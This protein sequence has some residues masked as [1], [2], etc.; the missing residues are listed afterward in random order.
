MT[1]LVD[2]STRVL[3][4]GI[5]G[6]EGSFHTRQ[7]VEYG[8]N[9]VAGVTPGKGGQEFEGIPV[10]DTVSAAVEQTGADVSV[11]FVPPP[12]AGD[13]IM[14]SAEAGI[15]LVVC[16]TEGIPVTD[17]VRAY[18]YIQQRSTRLIG[19]NCPGIMRSWIW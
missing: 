17:M 2:D 1:I 18:Q 6:G 8:T 7:M 5:T 14:E 9:V 16:I 10:Y 4:Q 11:I 12:F 19:P 3:V 15:D 13:A